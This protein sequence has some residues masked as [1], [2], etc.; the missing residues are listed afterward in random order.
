MLYKDSLKEGILT[1][2]KNRVVGISDCIIALE[3]EGFV[4]NKN[5]DTILKWSGI[6][7]H[8]YENVDVLS[9][10]QQDKLDNLFNK[11][12]NL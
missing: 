12:I 7:I 6:L 5:K 1:T 11:V 4:P 10:E 9:K 8:A 3:N 2:L